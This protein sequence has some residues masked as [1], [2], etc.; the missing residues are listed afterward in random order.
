VTYSLVKS[1]ILRDFRLAPR[2]KRDLRFFEILRSVESRK[3]V[4]LKS[5]TFVQIDYLMMATLD[6]VQFDMK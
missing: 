6:E 4:D 2:C 3:S 5:R 1:H